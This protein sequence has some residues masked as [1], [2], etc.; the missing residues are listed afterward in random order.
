MCY[1]WSSGRSLSSRTSWRLSATTWRHLKSLNKRCDICYEFCAVYNGRRNIRAH[2]NCDNMRAATW[3]KNYCY[4]CWRDLLN[5]NVSLWLSLKSFSVYIIY[6]AVAYTSKPFCCRSW[7]TSS[8]SF[9]LRIYTLFKHV[10]VFYETG[11]T[12]R[13]QL[14]GNHPWPH[15]TP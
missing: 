13:R 6:C 3:N 1:Q 14:R 11:L 9:L 2:I 7:R 5:S 10:C 15:C 8:S 4:R 12:K